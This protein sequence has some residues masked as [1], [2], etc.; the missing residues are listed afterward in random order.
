[1]EIHLNRWEMCDERNSYFKKTKTYEVGAYRPINIR[2]KGYRIISP[3][4]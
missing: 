1:M 3:V 2:A 4:I